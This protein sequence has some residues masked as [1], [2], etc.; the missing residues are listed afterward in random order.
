MRRIEYHQ[1]ETAVIKRHIPKISD[2]IRMYSNTSTVTCYKFCVSNIH[3]NRIRICFIKP[4]H[5][6]ATTGIKYFLVGCH[7][8]FLWIHTQ[9][10]SRISAVIRAHSAARSKPPMP[11]MRGSWL[12]FVIR[13][14]DRRPANEHSGIDQTVQLALQI[15]PRIVG[16]DLRV[17]GYERGPSRCALT[18]DNGFYDVENAINECPGYTVRPK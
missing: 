3:V 18:F 4:H 17:Q 1:F 7:F 9:Q 12:Q 10:S 14:I 5:S 8:L 6:I 16:G 2:Q 11:P 15:G 13:A